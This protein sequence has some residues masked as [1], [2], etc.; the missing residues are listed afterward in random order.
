MY[1][2]A[3]YCLLTKIIV[4]FFNIISSFGLADRFSIR[5][6]IK[7]AYLN[8]TQ[9][10]SMLKLANKIDFF[11]KIGLFFLVFHKLQSYIKIISIKLLTIN[12]FSTNTCF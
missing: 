1:L 8:K 6:S 12:F 10:K 5:K 9:A 2:Q 4:W 3:G 11:R 7:L